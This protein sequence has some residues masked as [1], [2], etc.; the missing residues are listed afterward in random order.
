MLRPSFINV[1]P[2][3]SSIHSRG[4]KKRVT[5]DLI[6]SPDINN[7][8]IGLLLGD[9]RVDRQNLNH[10]A[11]LCFEQGAI[12]KDYL[13]HLF[14]ILKPFCGMPSP[15]FRSKFHKKTG[16]SNDSYL[17]AYGKLSLTLVLI[18]ITPYFIPTKSKLFPPLL[19]N[20]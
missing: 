13:F 15:S 1:S 14:D 5:N 8:I 16:N 19:N 7:V 3:L 6:I 20:Y 4:I 2:I 12:H 11:R 9:A 17:L 10:S 18:I